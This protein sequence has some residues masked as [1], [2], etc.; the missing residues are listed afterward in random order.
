MIS[1]NVS[2]GHKSLNKWVM[3]SFEVK[4]FLLQWI[5]D[6]LSPFDLSNTKWHAHVNDNL[7]FRLADKFQEDI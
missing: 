6:P 7:K 3:F 5:L 4:C 2:A 1:F